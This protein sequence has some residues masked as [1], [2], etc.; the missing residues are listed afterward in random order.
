[1]M[2]LDKLSYHQKN[3]KDFIQRLLNG[4]KQTGSDFTAAINRTT[5]FYDK[6]SKDL[7]FE[8]SQVQSDF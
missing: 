3:S 4:F 5:D 2:S 8:L 7:Q 1:M 6:R